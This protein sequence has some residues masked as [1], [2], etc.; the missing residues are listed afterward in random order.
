M[1]YRRKILLAL[2]ESFGGTLPP[3]DC[4]LLLFLFCLRTQT[5][6]YDFFPHALGGFSLVL[7]QDKRRLT[8]L[9][10]LTSDQ[11]FQLTGSQ[12]YLSQLK[13]KDREALQTFVA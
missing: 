1:F 8:D 10:L 12:S 11:D 7:E 13:K 6:Y 3:I 5:N 9:G 4:R 2:V